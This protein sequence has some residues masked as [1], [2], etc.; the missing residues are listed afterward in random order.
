MSYILDISIAVT[1][2]KIAKED[3]VRFYSQAITG[4]EANPLIKTYFKTR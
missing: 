2:F 4:E 1:E 3:V